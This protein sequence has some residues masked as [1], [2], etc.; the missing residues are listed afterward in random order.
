MVGKTFLNR[1]FERHMEGLVRLKNA[2][3]TMPWGVPGL[4]TFMIRLSDMSPEVCTGKI[5]ACMIGTFSFT[6]KKLMFAPQDRFGFWI[7]SLGFRT[8]GTFFIS[9]TWIPDSCSSVFRIPKPRI[10]DSTSKNFLDSEIRI[11]LHTCMGQWCKETFASISC[12]HD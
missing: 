11:A 10:L 5:N 3:M 8:P 9:G 6:G 2:F 1:S 4:Y 12:L 7:P